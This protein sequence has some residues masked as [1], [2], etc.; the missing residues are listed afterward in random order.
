MA[1]DNDSLYDD[2]PLT[3]RELIRALLEDDRLDLDS[4]V[5]VWMPGTGEHLNT[6]EV[7][8]L[9]CEAAP[10][11]SG[12]GVWLHTVLN[13]DDRDGVIGETLTSSD[14]PPPPGTIVMDDCG[15]RW[16][17]DDDGWWLREGRVD[18]DPESWNKIAGNYGPV[19]VVSR[20]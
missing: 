16:T 13:R 18:S 7:D 9:V 10:H 4:H 3:V 20:G 12:K 11:R 6:G 17:R 19:R 1:D 14:T 5:H 2:K 8:T 15:V